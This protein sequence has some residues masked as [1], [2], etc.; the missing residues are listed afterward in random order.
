MKK[1]LLSIC[2]ATLLGCLP[3]VAQK[4]ILDDNFQDSISVYKIERAKDGSYETL[5]DE[6]MKLPIGETVVL[7]RLLKE[8][9][10]YGAITIIGKEYGVTSHGLLFSDENPEGT[11]DA[12]GDTRERTNHSWEGKFFATFTPYAIIASMFAIAM[13]FLF[14]GLANKIIR[15][16]ALVVVPICLLGA[17]SMETWAYITLGNDA[18]W[19][20]SMENYGFWGSC[21]RV[22]PFVIFIVFQLCSIK[23]Y[24][25]LLIDK[26]KDNEGL[27]IKPMA[28][29]MIICLPL[30]IAALIIT[31]L[32]GYH[33]VVRDIVTVATFLLSF[34]IGASISLVKNIKTIGFISGLFFT[35]F[36]I[37]YILGSIVSIIG[38]IVIL[39]EL[40]FQVLIICAGI[41]AVLFTANNIANDKNSPAPSNN[42][43]SRIGQ[44][45]DG[46]WRNGDGKSYESR[47]Q[48]EYHANKNL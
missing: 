2:C 37:V 47:S 3:S 20:C 7:K 23:G 17:T 46:T 24:E 32:M 43:R 1:L 33:G 41:F 5:G 27:S 13:I 25:L 40:I 11:E 30:T 36:S 15:R 35:L 4:Y 45:E 29:S 38:L 26:D 16:I 8:N 18:F 31:T 21:L 22:I 10:G 19:W 28:I 48:A 9:S 12:F 39:L 42:W 44:N 6:V 14:I 34:G